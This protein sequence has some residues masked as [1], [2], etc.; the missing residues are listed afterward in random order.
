MLHL[1][2]PDV[3]ENPASFGQPQVL[4]PPLIPGIMQHGGGLE[5]VLEQAASA[6]TVIHN[7]VAIRKGL[8]GPS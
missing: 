8:I 3:T 7:G 2:F 5:V 6:A 1:P 4:A